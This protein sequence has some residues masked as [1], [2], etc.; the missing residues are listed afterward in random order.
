MGYKLPIHLISRNPALIKWASSMPATS[1]VMGIIYDIFLWL[2]A[3]LSSAI[4]GAIIG[5]RFSR[6]PGRELIAGIVTQMMFLFLSLVIAHL[7]DIEDTITY[8]IDRKVLIISLYS[9]GAFL[10]ISVLM[11]YINAYLVQ[12][13]DAIPLPSDTLRRSKALVLFSLIVLAP[14]G[15]ETL[16][17]GLAESYLIISREPTY[18][19]ILLPALLFTMIHIQPLKRT[20]VLLAEVFLVGVLLSYLRT[21]TASLIPAIIGHSALNIGGLLV[22]SLIRQPIHS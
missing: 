6:N 8:N 4:A 22:F 11:N 19:V 16:F 10:S 18:V 7:V 13:Y 2:V 3:F 20:R 5:S 21:V 12:G 14:L 1:L 9:F 15:E 17:R